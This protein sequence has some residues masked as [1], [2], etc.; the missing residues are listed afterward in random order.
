MKL[1][2]GRRLFG[3][4]GL[5][6]G[7]RILWLVVPLVTG[8]VSGAFWFGGEWSQGRQAEQDLESLTASIGTLQQAIEQGHKAAQEYEQARTEIETFFRDQD[9]A[10]RALVAANRERWIDC[11]IGPDG[12]RQWNHWNQGPAAGTDP[13][14][15]AGA[16]AGEPA[17]GRQ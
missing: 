9:P 10:L 11:G 12:L 13:G 2:L 7:L 4:A 1:R 8:L 5:F 3:A 14:E 16:A 6:S 15:P 17:T